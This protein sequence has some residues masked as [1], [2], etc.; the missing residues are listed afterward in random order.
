M[1]VLDL[2]VRLLIIAGLVV[3]MISVYA[4]IKEYYNFDNFK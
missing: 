3:C 2:I 1:I 4:D